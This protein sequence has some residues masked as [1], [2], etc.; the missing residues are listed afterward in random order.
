MTE[1][2]TEGLSRIEAAVASQP[3]LSR[4]EYV[5]YQQ[6]CT[7][8]ERVKG[9]LRRA[10]NKSLRGGAGEADTK[11]IAAAER[12]VEKHTA[13]FKA[14]V[15]PHVGHLWAPTRIIAKSEGRWSGP[16]GQGIHYQECEMVLDHKDL[17]GPSYRTVRVIKDVGGPPT[18]ARQPFQVMGVAWH[19]IEDQIR[20]G[21]IV[22]VDEGKLS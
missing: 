17:S 16:S 19:A 10:K 13:T 8:L 7:R 4:E 3:K 18:D 22:V 15:D 14:L 11:K 9:D 2:I 6:I 5:E 21:D 1:S 12:G 20:R